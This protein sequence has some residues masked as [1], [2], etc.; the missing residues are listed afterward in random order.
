[1]SFCC[2]I[3]TVRSK[4]VWSEEAWKKKEKL[5][6]KKKKKNT[7]GIKAPSMKP[8]GLVQKQRNSTP[9]GGK[10]AKKYFTGKNLFSKEKRECNPTSLLGCG[11]FRWLLNTDYWENSTNTRILCCKEK[12]EVSGKSD[13]TR[14]KQC[15]KLYLEVEVQ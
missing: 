10:M 3:Y 2:Y 9:L 5:C 13:A 12:G 8:L 6:Q 11:L 7:R 14:G 1:M 15:M 4:E